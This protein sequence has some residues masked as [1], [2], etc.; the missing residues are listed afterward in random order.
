MSFIKSITPAIKK[1]VETSHLSNSTIKKV[2]QEFS[3]NVQNLTQ[4]LKEVEPESF[5][6]IQ[7][8]LKRFE[9]YGFSQGDIKYLTQHNPE[10]IQKL[11]LIT[12]KKVVEALTKR[13]DLVKKGILS[14]ITKENKNSYIKLLNDKNITEIGRAHV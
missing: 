5:T 2:T 8:Y 3:T 1:T 14:D 10:N 6:S 4:L 7:K 13:K 12:D 11:E 9:R